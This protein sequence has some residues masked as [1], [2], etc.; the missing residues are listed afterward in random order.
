MRLADFLDRRSSELPAADRQLLVD[1]AITLLDDAYVHLEL[2]RA[3]HA[4]EPIQRLRLLRDQLEPSRGRG[5]ERPRFSPDDDLDLHVAPRPAHELPAAPA[6]PGQHRLPAVP[7]GGI[8]RGRGAPLRRH[9][10]PGELR[11]PHVRARGRGAAL[12]RGAGRARR[13]GERPGTGRQQQGGRAGSRPR[14]PDDPA[15]GARA[16]ARRGLG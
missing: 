15:A 7:R 8:L 11:G 6:L 16:S 1:Q 9:S 5:D 14:R 10:C 2:K 12:E 13:R 4:V 3:M